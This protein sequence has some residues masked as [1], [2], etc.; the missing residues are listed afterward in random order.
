MW[1]YN[2][3]QARSQ[4]FLWGDAIQRGDGPNDVR[5]ASLSQG[6]GGRGGESV[7][8]ESCKSVLVAS[9]LLYVIFASSWPFN[10]APSSS[11]LGRF[12]EADQNCAANTT[13][14]SYPQK[15]R[16]T[17]KR[18]NAT[19]ISFRKKGCQIHPLGPAI[20]FKGGSELSWISSDCFESFSPLTEGVITTRSNRMK[21]RLGLNVGTSITLN[22]YFIFCLCNMKQLN[23]F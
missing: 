18:N 12:S 14:L 4:D 3:T 16:A 7:C 2:A 23:Q 1:N 21:F 15:Q 6:V 13:F 20:C 8:K 5:G 22:T 11:F 9:L 17:Q 19:F 10:S